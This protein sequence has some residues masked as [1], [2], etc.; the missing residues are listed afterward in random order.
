[1]GRKGTLEERLRGTAA[2]GRVSAKTGWIAGVS[3][4]S[5]Y[6][7]P[8]GGRACVFSILIEYPEEIG[9][10]NTG[11]FKKLQDELVLLLFEGGA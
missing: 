1:M 10:L 4:L 9:G 8:E 2:A 5:G 3:A 7:E 6:A 11:A